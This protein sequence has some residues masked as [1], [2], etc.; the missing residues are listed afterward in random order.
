MVTLLIIFTIIEKLS[1]LILYFWSLRQLTIGAFIYGS[2]LSLVLF[3]ISLETCFGE[4]V[5]SSLFVAVQSLE[6]FNLWGC[7]IFGAVGLLTVG[8]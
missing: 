1:A 7:R 8:H 6:L 2:V 5:Y 4:L 3:N